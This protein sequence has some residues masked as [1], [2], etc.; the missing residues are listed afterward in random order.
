M[1]STQPHHDH[2]VPWWAWANVL[3]F[4]AVAVGLLWQLAFSIQFLGRRP[5]LPECGIIGI[6]IWLAYTADRLLD[7]ATF[8]ER[9]AH[10]LRHR[11]HFEYRNAIASVW[12]L[13]L[14][15]NVAL[16]W[17]FA[18]P[19]QL[20]WGMLATATVIAY[21]LGVHVVSPIRW[22]PKE[23]RA[24]LTFAFGVS[25]STWAGHAGDVA[26]LLLATLMTGLLFAGNCLAVACWEKRLDAQQGF[27][28]SV[29]RYPRLQGWLPRAMLA[30][31]FLSA[32]CCVAGAFP[33]LV[34]MCLIG[35]D[36]LLLVVISRL[37]VEQSS[38]PESAT[39]TRPLGILSDIALLVPPVIV[40]SARL[41]VS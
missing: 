12:M 28:S 7:S 41:M 18:E 33:M 23:L 1:T 11:F 14:I 17:N 30:H 32:L 36:L 26:S 10:T 8:D 16:I 2:R 3:S 40:V 13:A 27:E 4:D 34:G 37:G 39:V 20:R 29:S 9:R 24:G 19:S 21:G 5:T 15:F 22:F 35:S 31:L 6:S 38:L 25:L